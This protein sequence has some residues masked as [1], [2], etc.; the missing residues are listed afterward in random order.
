SDYNDQDRLG[1][2]AQLLWL[3]SDA[4]RVR[5]AAEH[6]ELDQRCCASPLLAPVRAGLQAA[7]AYMGYE[8]VG[9]DPYSREVDNDMA[10]LGQVR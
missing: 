5:F 8:R 7:D 2:R 9:T 3:P 6:G 1:A 10:P 4:W